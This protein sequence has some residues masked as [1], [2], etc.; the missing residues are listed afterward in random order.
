VARLF[1]VSGAG[2]TWL[3]IPPVAVFLGVWATWRLI[4]SWSPRAP[5]AALAVALVFLF[6]DGGRQ[7]TFG[8]FFLTR[9]W[10]GKVVFLIWVVP[11][12]LALLTEW[13]RHPNRGTAVVMAG[14]FVASIGLTIT[15]FMDAPLIALAGAAP[16]LFR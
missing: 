8:N 15:A 1:H 9:A 14:G 10:Q 12:L 5:L 3:V 6:T 2:V 16:L 13:A 7:L 4:R 11:T